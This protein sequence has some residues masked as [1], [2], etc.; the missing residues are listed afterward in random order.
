[1]KRSVPKADGVWNEPPVTDQ[2]ESCSG[3]AALRQRQKLAVHRLSIAGKPPTA[4]QG[5]ESSQVHE[6]SPRAA[7]AETSQFQLPSCAWLSYTAPS[8]LTMKW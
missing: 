6:L 3:P 8:G 5:I 7:A 2:Q 4:S 1:M